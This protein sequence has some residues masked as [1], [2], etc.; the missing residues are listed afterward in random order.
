MILRKI[1][2]SECQINFRMEDEDQNPFDVFEDKDQAA[3]ITKAAEYS[4]AAWFC[5][6]VSVQWIGITSDTEYLGCCNYE[7]EEEFKN[8]LD[9][10][11]T[12]MCERALDSLNAKVQDMYCLLSTLIVK[13][14]SQ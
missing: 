11:Y 10:Y 5:A 14:P 12:D 8:P 3:E 1:L 2:L 9:G 13:E 4:K 7:S 6:A